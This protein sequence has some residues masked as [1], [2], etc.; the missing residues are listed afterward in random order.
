MKVYVV[1]YHDP[2]EG[3]DIIIGVTASE[4]AAKQL[5]SEETL[6][7]EKDNSDYEINDF[8][9]IEQVDIPA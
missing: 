7:T 3:R 1:T 4:Y 9:V 8:N 6:E 5:I 2:E